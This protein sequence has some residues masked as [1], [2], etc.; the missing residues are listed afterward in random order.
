MVHTLPCCE[1]YFNV[2]A[3]EQA[4]KNFD[5]E[6]TSPTVTC[7]QK[8]EENDEKYAYEEENCTDCDTQ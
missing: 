2:H 6:T 3:M 1:V 4:R 7:R 5:T 8:Q